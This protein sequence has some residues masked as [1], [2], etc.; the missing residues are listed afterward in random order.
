MFGSPGVKHNDMIGWLC[1]ACAR[2]DG[3]IGKCETLAA[4]P[5]RH[6]TRDKGRGVR[7]DLLSG[8]CSRLSDSRT[9][10]KT[11]VNSCARLLYL[12]CTRSEQGPGLRLSRHGCCSL[13]ANG[14]LRGSSC[15][16]RWL[17]NDRLPGKG[18]RDGDRD[19]NM[20]GR[21]CNSVCGGAMSSVLP[22]SGSRF[23]PGI[24]RGLLGTHDSYLVRCD[25]ELR[26]CLGAGSVGPRKTALPIL[27]LRGL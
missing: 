8:L 4:T 27:L 21:H 25:P 24:R 5:H 23:C 18:F 9:R 26:S 13:R 15:D 2:Y 22:G 1:S 12:G 10:D 17:D 6:C 16:V 14:G 19:R 20:T 7:C 3:L 11:V